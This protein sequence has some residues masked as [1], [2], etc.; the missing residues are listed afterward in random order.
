M[1]Y[2]TQRVFDIKTNNNLPIKRKLEVKPV[3]Y[4]YIYIYIYI[5]TPMWH[6]AISTEWMT[7]ERETWE[8]GR[9]PCVATGRVAQQTLSYKAIYL[10]VVFLLLIK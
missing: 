9:G 1:C 2:Q 7:Y 10:N 5:A 8:R 4:I 3:E 6:I